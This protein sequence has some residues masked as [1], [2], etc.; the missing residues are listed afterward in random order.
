MDTNITSLFTDGWLDRVGYEW[1]V[2][3]MHILYLYMIVFIKAINRHTAVKHNAEH[4]DMLKTTKTVFVQNTVHK[5][6]LLF[7]FI[8]NFVVMR[9]RTCAI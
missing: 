8:G 1:Q 5:I 3:N 6:A 4:T 9:S 2:M 7:Y